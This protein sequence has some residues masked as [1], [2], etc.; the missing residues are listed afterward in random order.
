MPCSLVILHSI[1]RLFIKGHK[2]L[3]EGTVV[4]YL[5]SDSATDGH[6]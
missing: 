1:H 4:V 6:V 2:G 3:Y 5:L